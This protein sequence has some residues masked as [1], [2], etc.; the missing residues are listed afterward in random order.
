MSRPTAVAVT[1]TLSARGHWQAKV[2]LKVMIGSSKPAAGLLLRG[3]RAPSAP[4][5]YGHQQADAQH[6][7]GEGGEQHGLGHRRGGACAGDRAAD[8]DEH[9]R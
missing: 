5:A 7:D 9:R 3:V 4:L 8:G 2:G 1:S 6:Q